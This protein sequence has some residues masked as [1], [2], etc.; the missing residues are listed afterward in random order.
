MFLT[1]LTAMNEQSTHFNVIENRFYILWRKKNWEADRSMGNK[2]A[3][4]IIIPCSNP[5]GESVHVSIQSEFIK[6]L[7]YSILRSIL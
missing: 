7:L 4:V 5:S 3:S 6:R 2:L 1:N